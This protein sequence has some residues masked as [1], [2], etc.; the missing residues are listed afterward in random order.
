MKA[1]IIMGE[2]YLEREEDN[3]KETTEEEMGREISEREIIGWGLHAF[4]YKKVCF[5]LTRYFF[6]KKDFIKKL[7][8]KLSK[9]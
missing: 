2:N 4:F 8:I 1:E 3:G 7:Y 9:A 5:S 6:Y